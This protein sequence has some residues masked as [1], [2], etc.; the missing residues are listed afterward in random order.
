MKILL[1]TNWELRH[2]GGI[3]TYL[4]QMKR[5]FEQWGHHVDI[6]ARQ[7]G[8]QDY[9]FNHKPFLKNTSVKKMMDTYLRR[10]FKS[11][12]VYAA[13]AIETMELNRYGFEWAAA[14]LDLS[15]Y[16]ILHA[17]DVISAR[18][19][20]RVRPR[21]IPLISTIH[22]SLSREN[23]PGKRHPLTDYYGAQEY[24][25]IL[26]ANKTIVPSQ[27]MK[28]FFTEE[29]AVPAKQITTIP[30]GIDCEVLLQR[31]EQTTDL[32]VPQNKAVILCTARLS[33]VKGQ[34]VLMRAL[35]KLKMKRTDWIC[36]FAGSGPLEKL[37][38]NQSRYLELEHHVTFLGDRDDVPQL[39][40]L[41]DI[42]VLP[43]LQDNQPF[44]VMEAQVVGKAI[45][46]T[47]AGGIPEM[48][49]HGRTG[50]LSP[51]GKH[52]GLYQHL[53]QVLQD[54]HLRRTLAKNSKRW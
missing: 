30:Y 14:L 15:R 35:A 44:A 45:V 28:R 37:L 4:Q 19:L 33:P 51:A 43:S 3:A 50:L 48:V 46:T 1:A 34:I 47:D 41:A 53:L 52:N 2:S 17:Q 54:Q 10:H 39:L 22:G 32:K 25:G 9:T 24:Y 18:A 38:K 16:H 31:S 6:L 49:V 29:Y 8:S 26:S 23:V 27:W 40:K 36:L 13:P 21:K 20:A 11:K 42:V 12:G 5:G 7:D